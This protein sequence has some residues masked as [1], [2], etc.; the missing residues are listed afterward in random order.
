MNNLKNIIEAY[1]NGADESLLEAFRCVHNG[2]AGYQAFDANYWK[3]KELIFELYADY[4]ADDRRLLKWLLKE[5]QKAIEFDVPLYTTDV[6]AFMLYKYMQMEDVYDLFE[7]KFGGNT[8][9]QVYI[10]IELIFGFDRQEMKTYLK[11]TS[12]DKK[13]D[14]EIIETIE[15]YESNPN[16]SFK[17]RAE[18]IHYFEKRKINLIKNDMESAAD[19]FDATE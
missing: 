11:N 14:N 12:G 5:E 1:R 16:A 18:Y 9:R 8:D 19:Y 15:Q 7:A 13:R 3:R 10:D 6:C 4:S 2:Q 17:N